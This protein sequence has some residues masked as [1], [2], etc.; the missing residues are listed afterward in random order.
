MPRRVLPI[1][2]L[3]AVLAAGLSIPPAG[4]SEKPL[5]RIGQILLMGN[6][7]VSD[8]SIFAHVPLYPGQLLSYTELRKAEKTLAKLGLF[9]VDPASGVRP[10]IAVLEREDS[11]FK[12]ILITVKEKQDKGKSR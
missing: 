12:D 10:T 7:R 1:G 8:E 6:E 3:L 5:A 2:V 4:A 9:V 11:E